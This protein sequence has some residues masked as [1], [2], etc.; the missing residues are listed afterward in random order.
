MTLIFFANLLS[1]LL[2]NVKKHGL[3]RAV[4]LEL[5]PKLDDGIKR[6]QEGDEEDS[7]EDDQDLPVA[8]EPGLRFVRRVHQ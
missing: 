6:D 1:F 5:R 4:S 8:I 7:E 3:R 2:A